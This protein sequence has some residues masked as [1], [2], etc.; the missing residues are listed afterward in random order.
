MSQRD[1][2]V[3]IGHMIDTANKAIGADV[4]LISNTLIKRSDQSCK[5]KGRSQVLMR[6]WI[7]L[8]LECKND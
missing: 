4:G 1:D 7:A 8:L 5:G 3:Y 2:Q 6:R